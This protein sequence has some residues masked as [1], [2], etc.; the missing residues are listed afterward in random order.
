MITLL[1]YCLI[2]KNIGRKQNCDS[3]RYWFHSLVVWFILW[4]ILFSACVIDAIHDESNLTALTPIKQ[5][6]STCCNE[7][8]TYGRGIVEQLWTLARILIRKKTENHLHIFITSAQQ[9]YK[10]DNVTNWKCFF[11]LQKLLVV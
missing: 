3:L 6:F 8:L 5:Q 7:F 1:R 11:S 4:I 9:L 2:I 10:M